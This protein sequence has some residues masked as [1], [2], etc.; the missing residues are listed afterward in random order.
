MQQSRQ[1]RDTCCR[2]PTVPIRTIDREI[3][4]ERDIK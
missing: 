3:T 2:A 1:I 4:I